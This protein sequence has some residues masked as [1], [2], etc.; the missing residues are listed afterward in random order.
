MS[1][2]ESLTTFTGGS[3]IPWNFIIT[4][5]GGGYQVGLGEFH[6][7]KDGLYYFVINVMTANVR[8]DVQLM[9]DIS[10]ISTTLEHSS[11]NGSSS[12]S[13]VVKC[14]REQKVW[15]RCRPSVTCQ[16]YGYSQYRFTTFSGFLIH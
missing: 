7:P 14:E 12:I 16:V 15:A 10:V 4:N 8:A 9:L 13:A 5:Q 2:A 6:C 3:K 1:L 11:P